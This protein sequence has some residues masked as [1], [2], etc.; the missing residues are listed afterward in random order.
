LQKLISNEEPELDLEAIEEDFH[1]A[2]G[3]DQSDV[4]DWL[5]K[6]EEFGYQNPTEGETAQQA[7]E[8]GS[9]EEDE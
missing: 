3:A 8:G 1:R 4:H 6:D 7:E 2:F 5:N 9:S